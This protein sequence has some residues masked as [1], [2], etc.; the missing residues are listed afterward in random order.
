MSTFQQVDRDRAMIAVEDAQ[1]VVLEHVRPVG[2]E[3]VRLP[4][5]L[6]RVLQEEVG[7]TRDVPNSDNSAMDGYAVIAADLAG[8]SEATPVVL[9]VSENL[10]AGDVSRRPVVSG[11]AARIMTGAPIPEGADAVVPVEYTDAGHEQVSI[12]TSFAAGTNVRRRG[13]DMRRGEIVLEPGTFLRPAE[14]GVLATLQRPFVEVAKRPQVAV[15]STGS[16]IIDLETTLTPGKIVNSNAYSLGA[17]IRHAGASPRPHPIT[18]DSRDSIINAIKGS[19][20]ADLIVSSGGASVGAYDFIKDAL[21]AVGAEIFFWQVAMKPG[22]PVI[23]ATIGDRLFF[24]LPGNPVSCMVAFHL[25]VAP[26][27]RRAMGDERDV[28]PPTVRAR[29]T[30][31][32]KVRGDRRQYLRVSVT[33]KDGELRASPMT[34]QG[35]GVSTSML[36]ANGLAVVEHDIDLSAG[37]IVETL[38][39]EPIW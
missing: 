29:L 18:E 3:K 10:P 12:R 5:A 34:S 36:G 27:I 23:F 37:D 30:R 21:D 20:E 15:L 39:I 25:F 19:M 4:D 6:G 14:I 2:T 22:K 32:L 7:A 35:S 24:G 26:A 16:E 28:L 1:S 11:S 38:L 8:A 31:D 33:V 13:E 9:L 17:L